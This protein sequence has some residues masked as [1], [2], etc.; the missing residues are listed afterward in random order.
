MT[1]TRYPVAAEDGGGVV[2]RDPENPDA[3]IR[4]D[5]VVRAEDVE[6]DRIRFETV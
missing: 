3:W 2:L 1:E 6:R 5:T 4:S